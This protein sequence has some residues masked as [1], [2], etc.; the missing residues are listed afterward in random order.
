VTGPVLAGALLLTSCGGGG[1]A[2]EEPSVSPSPSPSSTLD[3]PRGVELTEPGT[4]LSYGETATVVYEQNRGTVL[5]LTVE[6]VTE[7]SIRDL[8]SFELDEQIRSSTPY[9]V[10]VSVENVGEGEI[11]GGG[12]PLFGVAPDDTLL[13]AARFTTR[14]RRCPSAQLPGEFAA[15]DTFGGC[16]VYLVPDGGELQAVSYRPDQEFDAVTWTGRIASP[17]PRPG[18]PASPQPDRGR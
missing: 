15:G 16:L 1:E 14:F 13:P 7:G 2:T 6:S 8:R 17:G 3:L 5:D 11:G 9:Y 10:R 12:V 4:R 18:R